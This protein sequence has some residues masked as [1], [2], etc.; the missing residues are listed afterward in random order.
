M[1]PAS[2]DPP[3]TLLRGDLQGVLKLWRSADG[4][5]IHFAC[6]KAT[7]VG[8]FAGDYLT[9]WLYRCKSGFKD[10]TGVIGVLMLEEA[11]SS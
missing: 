1:G 5:R 7:T 9:T 6:S 3:T 4:P 8:C 2:A 11:E 10:G